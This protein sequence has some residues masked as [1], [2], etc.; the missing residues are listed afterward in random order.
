MPHPLGSKHKI[1]GNVSELLLI[2][3]FKQLRLEPRAA[4]AIAAKLVWQA[5]KTGKLQ[6]QSPRPTAFGQDKMPRRFGL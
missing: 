6:L 5:V 3:V 4:A 2:K 1:L